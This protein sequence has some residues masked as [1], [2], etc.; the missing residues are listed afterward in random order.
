MRSHSRLQ[1]VLVSTVL[2]LC[3]HS[4]LAQEARLSGVVSD[5]AGAAIVGA[6]LTATQTER[7]IAFSTKAGEDG[8]YLFPRLPSGTY[9]VR[10][11]SQGFR[12]FV[13][14]EVRIT[15]GAEALLNVS[16]R[17]GSVTEE[18]TV[19]GDASRVNTESSTIQQLVDSERVVDLPLNGRDVYQLAK[20]V[21]GTGANGFDIAGGKSDSQDSNMVNVRLDGNLNVNTAYGAILPTPS[22]DAV[23]EFAVQTSLPSARYGWASGVVEVETR[24]G[25][26]A[27]HGSLYEFFRNDKLDARSF[28]MASKT[29]RRRNQYGV[30][31][32]GPFVVPGIY[33]GRNKTFWF[34][35]FEQMKEPVN[36]TQTTFVPTEAQLRGDF[37]ASSRVIRD[38]VN[39]QPFP[40][41]VIPLSRIDPIAINVMKKYVPAPQDSTGV[42]RFQRPADNNP[43][44][45]LGRV[46]QLIA[47][48]HQLSFRSFHTRKQA[49]LSAG[50]LPAFANSLTRSETDFIGTSH[51][52]TVSPNKINTL[53]Y[54]FNGSYSNEDLRPK[55]SDQ[56]LVEMGWSPNFRRYND[57]MPSLEVSG[58]FTVSRSNSTLRDYTTHS[59]S[60]DFS[61]IHGRHAMM[62]GFDGIY[63]IQSGTSVSRTHGIFTYS[64]SLSGL[65][66][67]DFM[68]GRPSNL[69]Q[70][71]QAIDRTLGMHLSWYFQDDFKINKRLTMNLGV[72]YELPKPVWSDLGQ[73]A[74]YRPGQQSTVYPNAPVGLLY[75]GDQGLGNAGYEG[76]MNYWAPRVGLAYALTSDQKTVLRT[77]Y[78]IY[79]A[80]TW[81]NILGQFQVYQPFTRTIDLA[82]PPSTSDPWA[83]YP[84]GNP[85]P[86]DRTK[87]AHFDKQITGFGY[88]PGYRELSMQQW[89]FGIQREF[90][91]SLLATVSYVG[92]R[93]THIPYSRDINPATYIPGASTV[94]NLNSRRPMYPDFA[95]FSLAE[96]VVNA[97]YNAL[98]ATLDRRF[99]GGLT[100][101]LGYTFSKTLTDLETVI[102]NDGGTQ[103]P[104]NRS[105]ERGPAD[106]HR[107]HAFHTSWVWK[108]PFASGFH[109]PARVLLHGWQVTGI[110]SMYSGAPLLFKTNQDR[111]L[112]GSPNRPD[113]LK[114]ARLDTSRPR[115][116]LIAKYFDTTAYVPNA[117][118]QFGSAPR[119]EAQLFGPGSATLTAGI[120]KR[121]RGIAESHGVQF[122]TEIFNALNRPNF[123]KPGTNVDSPGSF[124]RIT[125]ASDGRIIQFGLKYLF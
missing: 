98:Q 124:G 42:Y 13:Q 66:L 51:T 61:W 101:L 50:N 53:R 41:K 95:R 89:S 47:N 24:S 9:T 29:K 14:A 112:R 15:T 83:G 19:T 35:N 36:S 25:T 123:S 125:G 87:G 30:A 72:R 40:G 103:D 100:V 27:L 99:S 82:T 22:P 104:N 106:S 7:N 45:V 5:P 118:G 88:A 56:E 10:A 60:D 102:T 28:F 122:R 113:R 64:G 67:S 73:T 6:S 68:L 116:E 69:K 58:Y 1:T 85:H 84:G 33:N 4:A 78:G 46:D 80:P 52:W 17:L 71:N 3:A 31:V 39:N 96:S 57:N 34:L 65:G 107:T 97:D 21:P 119:A 20:L 44:N 90:T 79:F 59:F 18:I 48:R 110:L 12:P 49:P 37:S 91:R 38:P 92:T 86:Y 115:A 75:P 105:L 16:L 70:G 94:A 117:I 109:G 77:G 62:M 43:T 114:D 81:T 26:N 54:G 11:E 23:R 2:L 93:S 63:T 121:F 55:V 8:R 74:F 108:V 111:A 32:G 120:N 76:R